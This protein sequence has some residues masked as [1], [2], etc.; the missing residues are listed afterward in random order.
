MC[1][2]YIY[3]DVYAYSCSPYVSLISGISSTLEWPSVLLGCT[4]QLESCLYFAFEMFIAHA[5]QDIPYMRYDT[6]I[7]HFQTGIHL[8]V[9][10]WQWCSP[11][12][13]LQALAV[14]ERRFR[15]QPYQDDWNMLKHGLSGFLQPV[16]WPTVGSPALAGLIDPNIY[17]E[18]HHDSSVLHKRLEEETH[19]QTGPKHSIFHISHETSLN[20]PVFQQTESHQIPLGPMKSSNLTK[21]QQNST[22]IPAI[23]QVSSTAGWELW[24]LDGEGTLKCCLK[25]SL[26]EIPGR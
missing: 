8:Q 19:V 4:S 26:Q 20:I 16:L 15:T 13:E 24:G 14:G 7:A 2:L 5:I 11:D 12:P 3:I 17:H 9:V 21:F 6:V 25:R 1:I 22:T 18:S 23:G 10:Y